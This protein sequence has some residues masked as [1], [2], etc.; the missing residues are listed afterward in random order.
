MLI[1]VSLSP[2]LVAVV[3]GVDWHRTQ[4][5]AVADQHL[6]NKH[7]FLTAA[8]PQHLHHRVDLGLKHLGQLQTHITN[9]FNRPLTH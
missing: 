6:R 2:V 1:G 5:F 7:V 8:E 9:Y 3:D 4:L